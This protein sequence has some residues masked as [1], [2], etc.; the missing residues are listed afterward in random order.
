MKLGDARTPV[1]FTALAVASAL[2]VVQACSS[3]STATS[4]APILGGQLDTGHPAVVALTMSKPGPR[5]PKCTGTMIGVDLEKGVGYVLTAAHCA[6]DATDVLVQRGN[7]RSQVSE[8]IEYAMLDYRVSPAYPG[9][10]PS[11]DDVAIVRVLGVDAST[12][13]IPLIAAADSVG[14]GSAV[15]SVGFGRTVPP[16]IPTDAGVNT[17]KNRIDG[18]ITRVSQSI[19]T[20]GYPGGSTC[21]GDSG[22]PLIAVKDG[23]EVVVGV[24]STAQVIDGIECQGTAGHV[25]V[26]RS[27]AFFASV[28]ALPAPAPGCDVCRKLAT[29]GSASCGASK[30]SCAA[31]SACEAV[32]S[33]ISDCT[34]YVGDAGLD[35]G[36]AGCMAS[37]RAAYASGVAA[38]DEKIASCPC[39][40]CA[41]TCAGDAVCTSV[42]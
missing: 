36:V 10:V 7:D 40:V 27:S 30:R 11:A 39:R 22:G 26:K 5:F 14:T 23:H 32:R 25:D 29:S 3:P 37:C 21:V 31:D 12:P 24:Q 38:Y 9:F 15:L 19:F 28:F 42:Q 33:C 20:V 35:G 18:S 17:K 4:E 41:D 34:T 2:G 13:V 1:I 16:E 6:A 8:L